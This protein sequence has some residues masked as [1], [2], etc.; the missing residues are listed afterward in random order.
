[1]ASE[2]AV[3]KEA[4][5][6]TLPDE[7]NKPVNLK[8]LRGHPVVLVFYAFDWSGICEGEMCNFRDDYSQ[9]E[10]AGAKVLAISRDSRFSH[11]AWKT[12][13]RLQHTLL[14]DV[15]GEAAKLYGCWNEEAGRAERLTVVIDGKGIIRYVTRSPQVTV[16]RDHREALEAVKKL[17]GK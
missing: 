16:P 10:M 5:D 11:K 15:K 7:D 13:L 4:P 3:G 8:D 17:T 2:I 14:A 1:M 6:F 9:F 12:H